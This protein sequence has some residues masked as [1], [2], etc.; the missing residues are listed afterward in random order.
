MMEKEVKRAKEEHVLLHLANTAKC[1]Y[2]RFIFTENIATTDT[3]RQ[4]HT[5]CRIKV[6][7]KEV[8]FGE[9]QVQGSYL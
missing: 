9:S 7:K 4:S 8:W 3:H 6:Y 5:A 1:N 2:Y